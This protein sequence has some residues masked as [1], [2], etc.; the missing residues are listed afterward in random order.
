VGAQGKWGWEGKAQGKVCGDLHSQKP[1]RGQVGASSCSL[2]LL[3]IPLGKSEEA[4]KS[5]TGQ[6]KGQE[7]VWLSIAT[8]AGA[9]GGSPQLHVNLTAF[10]RE[11]EG[12][13]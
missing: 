12:R 2:A 13:G 9:A 7:Q 11:P 8:V 5:T 4:S 10:R 1:S 3:V 6:G